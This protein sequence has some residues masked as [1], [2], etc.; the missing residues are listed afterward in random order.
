[1]ATAAERRAA[2]KAA[3]KA[4]NAPKEKVAKVTEALVQEKEILHAQEPEA[5]RPSRTTSRITVT[6]A[7]KIPNGLILQNH[8]MVEGFEPVFGGGSRPIKTAV[9]VGNPIRLVG[10]SR[11]FGADPESKRVVGGY[12]LTY[13]VPKADFEKWMRD[14]AE[15]DMV[16]NGLIFS[17]ENSDEAA[18]KARD[19][20]STRSGLEPLNTESKD[21]AGKYLDPRMP[22]NIKKFNPADDSTDI[23]RTG[24]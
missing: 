5:D 6:V 14:N 22:R 15:L 21:A 10:P 17:H 8:D 11:P 13:N 20:R 2:R 12:A 23:S 19:M 9:K 4:A 1:M 16:K 18:A 7:C 24:A 3:E